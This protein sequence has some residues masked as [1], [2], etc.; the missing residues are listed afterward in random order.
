MSKTARILLVEDD[1]TFRSLLAAIL[2]D[3]GYEL[4][5]R[6]DG[7]AALKT[8]QGQSFDLVLSDLRLPGLNGL[9][10]FRRAQAEGIAPPFILLTAFGTVEEAVA[11]IKEGVADFLTKPLKDPE[12]LRTLVRRV[13]AGSQQERTLKVL[14]ER[15]TAGLPPDEVLFAGQAMQQV[16]RLIVDVAST[17][18]TV[19]ISGES[20][21]GKELAARMIHQASPRRDA[22]FVALNCAAIPETLLESELFG[23]EKG[24]FTG[25]TQARQG[26][27]ELA[28]G[29]TI[30]LD[31][32]GELPLALQSKF[33]RVLQERLFERVGGSREIRV[34]LRVVAATNRDL[35]EEVRERRFRED[36]YYRLNVF[37]LQLPALRDRRDGIPVLVRYLLQRAAL[38]TGRDL[39]DIEPQAL[40]ILSGYSWPGNIRELQNVIERAVILCKGA[41]TAADLPDALRQPVVTNASTREGGS[42]RDRE[43]ASILEALASCNNNR[44]LA[45][46]KLGISKRTLQYR[47]KEYGLVEP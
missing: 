32:I 34:D 3:D 20:G 35:A 47:L 23:H 18:A 22:P 31:E 5:E 12:T 44:R 33:L 46:E 28:S 4:V 45:A 36:L 37:P 19:L 24:A 39:Q 43:R 21:T 16:R 40:E 25:A 8:L 27:F 29:G 1:A 2:D 9:D 17:Q 41:L 38:Q 14:K 42:L 6:E 15:E 11:A 7:K 26:K 30:F 13:L 10:L